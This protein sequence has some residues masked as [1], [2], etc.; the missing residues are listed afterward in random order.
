MPE[1]EL[2]LIGRFS[3]AGLTDHNVDVLIFA[4]PDG[5]A[6]LPVWVEQM[7]DLGGRPTDGE[8][9]ATV[10]STG[11]SE[12]PWFGVLATN[13][14]GQMTAGIKQGK[15]YID[16]RPSTLEFMWHSGVLFDIR[17]GEYMDASLLP[18]NPAFIEE[19]KNMQLKAQQLADPEDSINAEEAEEAA[20]A[21]LVLRWDGGLPTTESA[22]VVDEFTDMWKAMGWSDDLGD[23]L[24]NGES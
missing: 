5:T 12:D 18:V 15:R 24:E 23:W 1:V 17:V 3:A 13:S 10:L 8:I 9:L 14:R 4:T 2:H 20:L 19:I 11:E 22:E 6:M 16:V 7:Q 21:A